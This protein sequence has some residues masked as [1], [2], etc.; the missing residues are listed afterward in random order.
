MSNFVKT[1]GEIAIKIPSD[2]NKKWV[3]LSLLRSKVQ[4]K[5]DESYNLPGDLKD[6]RD[7]GRMDS[8]RWLLSLLEEKDDVNHHAVHAV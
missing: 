5:Y 2:F 7:L 1:E 6:I 3:D 8:L 4:E